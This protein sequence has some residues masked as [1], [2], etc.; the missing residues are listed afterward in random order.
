MF[1]GLE[2]LSKKVVWMGGSRQHPD[3]YII[4]GYGFAEIIGTLG[5][6]NHDSIRL[7]VFLQGPWNDYPTHAHDSEEWCVF[8][9]GGSYWKVGAQFT[10]LPLTWSIF[11]GFSKKFFC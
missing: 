3:G 5:I 11:D 2:S 8:R 1:L 10:F 4:S 6:Y 7:G 9:G